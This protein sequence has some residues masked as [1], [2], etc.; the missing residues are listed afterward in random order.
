MNL[1]DV[2]AGDVLI[3]NNMRNRQPVK[4]GRTTKTQIILSNGYR[5][6][7]SSGFRVGPADRYHRSLVTI[8][9]KGEI[10]QIERDI[11]HSN[12]VYKID[13]LA[14][15]RALKLLSLEQLQRIM[16][17]L[18]TIEGE[19]C[20]GCGTADAQMVVECPHC[21]SQKCKACN[22]GDDVECG[23]CEAGGV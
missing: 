9:R 4:V 7:K 21:G 12:L 3:R 19:A 23:N 13:Q 17:L 14:D 6:R 15:R 16:S 22:P 10:E 5:Y 11:Q 18:K 8:P 2:K 20:E 1:N